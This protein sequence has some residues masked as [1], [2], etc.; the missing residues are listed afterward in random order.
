MN[1]EFSPDT[2]ELGINYT[3]DL[4]NFSADLHC[5]ICCHGWPLDNLS[6]DEVH[7]LSSEVCKEAKLLANSLSFVA[8]VVYINAIANSTAIPGLFPSL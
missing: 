1:K 5:L 3:G 7:K 2:T 6:I 8:G 4:V